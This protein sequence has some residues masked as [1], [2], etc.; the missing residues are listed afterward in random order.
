MFDPMRV[1]P[2]DRLCR[3]CR[4][5]QPPPDPVLFDLDDTP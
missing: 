3:D 5:A 1:V 2:D 4:A